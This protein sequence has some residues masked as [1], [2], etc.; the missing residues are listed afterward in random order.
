MSKLVDDS[1]VNLKLISRIEENI[2]VTTRNNIIE[3]QTSFLPECISR[4]FNGEDRAKSLGIIRS[5]IYTAIE[6]SD[7]E[8][9]STNMN[10]YDIKAD[11]VTRFEMDQFYNSCN[12]LK[13]F[14]IGFDESTK[15]IKNFQKTYTDD[16]NIV[17]NI[18]VLLKKIQK[19]IT[20]IERKL[21]QVKHKKE[22]SV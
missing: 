9:N 2:K 10:I 6:L 21:E 22:D 18:E 17:S 20:K 7:S 1:I 4:Y 3:S 8:M 12:T 11:D 13:H 19:Q 16:G 15:G 5:I 14:S